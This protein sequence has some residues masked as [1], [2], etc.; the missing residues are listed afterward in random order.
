MSR[1]IL[2]IGA[3]FLGMCAG[4]IA[5]TYALMNGTHRLMA[6]A[7]PPLTDYDTELACCVRCGELTGVPE[8]HEIY[9]R[10][11]DDDV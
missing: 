1:A 10:Q 6:K 2:I 11:R 7:R 5:A 4:I 9:C 8:R 3:A